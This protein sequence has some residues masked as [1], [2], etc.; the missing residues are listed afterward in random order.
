MELITDFVP[1]RIQDSISSGLDKF[2][3]P[4]YYG[5]YTINTDK[6]ERDFIIT[7]KSKE[8]SQFIHIFYWDGQPSSVYWPVVNPVL[9]LFEQKTGYRILNFG[10]IKANLLLQDNTF[11]E[12]FYNTP[13]IDVGCMDKSMNKNWYSLVYYVDDSDGDTVVFD[14]LADPWTAEY[15]LNEAGRFSPKKGQAVLF[16]SRRW[17]AS[18]P[19]KDNIKRRVINY[20]FQLHKNL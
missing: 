14:K 15:Q 1:P 19:P 4:W 7:D 17:H 18:T 6:S 3:F 5:S 2:D 20:V 12:G 9:G 16:D 8:S 13:H 11:P 10:R